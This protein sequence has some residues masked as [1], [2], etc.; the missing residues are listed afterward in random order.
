MEMVK[1]LGIVGAMLASLMIA[2][3]AQARGGRGCS[4]CGGG[5]VVSGCPGGSCYAPA[6]P[7]KYSSIGNAPPG[8]ASAPVADPAP[9]LV[10]RQT[11]ANYYY[12][13]SAPRR[14]LF[15]RR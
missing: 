9:V 2:D 8:L 5:Y 13:A 12:N 10:T 15:G 6:A 7:G 11:T 14:G 1:Y 4:S 3:Q